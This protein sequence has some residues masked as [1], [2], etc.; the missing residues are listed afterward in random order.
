MFN[1]KIQL[2][3]LDCA[4]RQLETAIRLYFLEQDPVSTH[5]LIS[6]SRQLLL[7]LSRASQPSVTLLLSD[8]HIK[9]EMRGEWR[10]L[11]KEAANFFKH[12]DQ[13]P[14]ATLDFFP[15]N[16]CIYL[17]DCCDLYYELSHER[18]PLIFLFQVW[19]WIALEKYL[20]PD[21]AADFLPGGTGY[22]LCAEYS[23]NDRRKFF[24]NFLPRIEELCFSPK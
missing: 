7:D 4:R 20:R 16:N 5:T 15:D 17:L 11:V 21:S 12:A 2:S 1:T 6:A 14:Q 18:P 8:E 22:A 3:K 10:K 19:C 13:D 9:P 23:A 24:V